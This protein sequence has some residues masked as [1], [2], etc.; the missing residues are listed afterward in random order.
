MWRRS[1]TRPR[2]AMLCSGVAV[3]AAAML[4]AD[5]AR[6]QSFVWGG[7]GS[8]SNT[9]A[10]SLDTNWSNP[11][12][13][14]IPAPPIF[15]TQ[16]AIFGSTGLSTVAIG[17]GPMMP[18]S[19]TFTT[20]SQAYIISGNAVN[21][22][23][24]GPTGGLINNANTGQLITIS[25]N[26]NDAAG[27]P[28][29][30]QQLGASTL[31]LAGTNG[32][33][34]GTLISAGT[35]QIT[36]SSALGFDFGA[37]TGGKVTLDGGTLKMDSSVSSIALD[38]S[39]FLN[40]PGGTVD[41]NGA[42]VNLTG[43]ISNGVGAGV[44]H[45]VDSTGTF[46]GNIQLSGIN[47]YTG[48]TS[49]SGAILVV[50]N[51]SA[52][53]TGSVALDNTSVFQA[54]GASN[55]TFTNKFQLTGT[56]FGPTFDP[57]GTTLMLAGVISGTGMLNV[58]NVMSLTGGTVLL[59]G[60]N[61]YG[62]GTFICSCVSL[63]L[64]DATHQAS[65]IGPVTNDGHF[66]IF[67][68]DTS[69]IT[70]LL[71]NG[72]I[73]T[74]RNSTT[75]SGIAITNQDGGETDFKNSSGAGNATIVNTSTGFGPG[76]TTFSNS[77]SAQNA[78]ITNVSGSG[79]STIFLGSSTAG[80]AVITNQS[81]GGNSFPFSFFGGS[82][83][84]LGFFGNSTAGNATIINNDSN[85]V[86]AFGYPAGF[87]P[88]DHATAG[89]STITN[90]NGGN[91]EFN[92]STTAGNA[93]ITTTSG[94]AV[95]FFDNSTG[96]NARFITN[97][98]GYVDFSASLGVHGDGSIG[99]GSIEGSGKYYIGAGNTLV[100]GSNNL[101][102]I[103]TGKI[104]DYNPSP[105]CGCPAFPGIGN[106]DK[107][108]AGTLSLNGVNTYTGTTTIDGGTLS[109]NGSIVTSSMTTVNTG[110]T[111][112]GN[113][114]VGDTTVAGGTLSPGNSIGLITIQGSLTLSTAAT[115]LVQISGV[116]ADKT[117]VTGMANLGGKVVVDPLTRITQT[118]TYTIL[119][120][121][122]LVGTF[123]S[124]NILMGNNFASNPVVTYV[125]NNVL[126]T[127]GV[128]LLTPG[129]PANAN[130]NQI[131]VAAGIDKALLGGATLPDAFNALFALSGNALLNG[132]TQ[133]SGEIATGTQQTTFN[134]MNL[135]MGLLLDP[136][137][138]GRGNDAPSPGGVSNYASEGAQAYAG[139][140]NPNDA[141]AAIY[142]KAPLARNY[143]PHW[144]V[145]AAA[146]GGSQTT[147]GNAVLGSNNMT[148]RI[149]GTVIGADYLLSPRTVVGFALAG[150]GTNFSVATGG[151]GRSDLFQA[152]AFV[153]HTVGQA[154]I[155]AAVGYGW[156]D[157]TTNRTVTV[158]GFDQLQARFNANAYSGRVEGGY[159]Y[160]LPWIGGLGV[161]PYAAGQFTTFSLPSYAEGVLSGANTFALAYG[162]RNVTDTRS[163]LGVRFDKSYA[164]QSAIL[165]LRGRAAWAHDFNPDRNI[166]ATFQTLPG[167][168]FVVN[169]AGL[170]SDSALTTASAE[171]K[172]ANRWSAAATF[173]GEFSN[174]TRSY[175]GKGVV[176]YQW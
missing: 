78:N 141:L 105:P 75:A 159:R 131:N 134:A 36:N 121:T 85:G 89:N 155:S 130:I 174:V 173:E 147:S 166:G 92:S 59:T 3:A 40:A 62:G 41:A 49:V 112:G 176:R 170:S 35:V 18:D 22:S 108:G 158:A 5:V 73:T 74:F 153:R 69:Q 156:Q 135:F 58:A 157:I 87:F 172:W 10:Y 45:I 65:I 136:F 169:G 24:S 110:G 11:S 149:F 48:G 119:T 66:S 175:A 26:I 128:G 34:G 106:L 31:L 104:L 120:S 150:G 91:L 67:N 118:T 42:Q 29:Q 154:Y 32:Y 117:V 55:L 151:F 167:A 168:S 152:G 25:T 160:V 94:S 70:T 103:L 38:N 122:G 93:T 6:A 164:L 79:S 114:F 125:G 162:A 161:T 171:I 144:S 146:Y 13:I 145:W 7:T 132:L 142:S 98:T 111:L 133:L 82:L 16:S 44:L 56:T 109:V 129:L 100:V 77:S 46:V 39:F 127:V 90:S 72:G 20:N 2:A 51:N 61:T 86:V 53:G 4:F 64:G 99:A 107:I 102:S 101:S 43:V 95:A 57:N 139:R 19:W 71:N 97:G 28:T 9:T 33:S 96:G 37:G 165:T 54:D 27:G 137:V 14:A 163:E 113:G 84:G 143:D 8:S 50:S 15:A 126:L 63:Q 47:T 30:V 17:A 88:V 83:P 60:V 76:L 140:R 1:R 81:S 124:A 115:Y 123:G 80:N 68:A 23:M 12:V 52:V 116:S 138:D 21:F 148:S